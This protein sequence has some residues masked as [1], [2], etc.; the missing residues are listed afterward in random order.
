MEIICIKISLAIIFTS[1][2]IGKLTGK[3]KS[4]FE[5]AGYSRELMYTTAFAEILLT[6]MLFTRFELWAALGLFA[7]IGGAFFTLLRQRAK[8][9]KYAM[10]F[11]AV[12]L[13]STLLC[14]YFS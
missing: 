2:A 1:A 4:T 8:P 3:T 5:Q 14:F 9:A 7:I 11:I 12:I 13:L 10:T 6:V